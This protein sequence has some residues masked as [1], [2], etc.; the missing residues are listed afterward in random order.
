MP[1]TN[2]TNAQLAVG[3]PIRSVDLLALRD[4]VVALGNQ[5]AGAPTLVKS[6]NGQTGTIVNNTFNSIG[7]YVGSN[8]VMT[9]IGGTIAGSTLTRRN[10]E[11]GTNSSLGVTGTYRN[12]GGFTFDSAGGSVNLTCIYVRIS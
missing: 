12:M 10:A 6:L 8:Y 5:E 2:I 9:S 7:C 11:T 3:A 1:W 4:N